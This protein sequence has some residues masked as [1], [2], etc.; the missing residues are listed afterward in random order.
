MLTRLLVLTRVHHGLLAI[1]TRTLG[2][3][4]T[5]PVAGRTGG[6]RVRVASVLLLT[7]LLASGAVSAAGAGG[8]RSTGLGIGRIVASG[9]T[10]VAALLSIQLLLLLLA[11]AEVARSTIDVSINITVSTRASS[12][13]EASTSSLRLW[14]SLNL[15]LLRLWPLWRLV[16]RLWS[17]L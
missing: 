5:S 3:V 4:S 16:G 14:P 6:I 10:G 7:N 11:S 2:A 13:L 15:L 8:A 9:S 1:A 12:L 17:L